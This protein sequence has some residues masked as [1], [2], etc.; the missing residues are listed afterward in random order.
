MSKLKLIHYGHP[1]LR[2]KAKP[3]GKPDPALVRLAYGMIETLHEEGGVGLAAPQVDAPISL[4]VLDLSTDEAKVNP[5]I[6]ANPVL[7]ESSKD[8]W[9]YEEGCLSVPEIRDI[10]RRPAFVTVQAMDLSGKS[11][12]IEKAQGLL[13][14][15]LQHEIDHLNGIFFV[16]RLTEEQRLKLRLELK[17]IEKETRR[18]IKK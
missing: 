4:I 16:D 13:A 2:K 17:R 3:V 7:V 9:G 15:V 18:K 11:V 8:L 5:V 14:R 10:V 6:L 1:T 12:T